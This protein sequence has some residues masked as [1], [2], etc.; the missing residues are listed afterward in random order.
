MYSA[1]PL[2]L[3]SVLFLSSFPTKTLTNHSDK[4]TALRKM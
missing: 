2:G 3:P 4:Y 1:L